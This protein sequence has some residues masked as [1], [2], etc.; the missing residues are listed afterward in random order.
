MGREVTITYLRKE[1]G[2]ERLSM[3][4]ET[5]IWYDTLLTKEVKNTRFKNNLNNGPLS[6]PLSKC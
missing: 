6:H 1:V 2:T 3:R 4:E 5:T